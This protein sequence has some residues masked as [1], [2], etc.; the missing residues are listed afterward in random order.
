MVEQ[1]NVF[2]YIGVE[3]DLL[4]QSLKKLERGDAVVFG[5]D[6]ARVVVRF[7]AFG[8]YEIVSDKKKVHEGFS[9][10]KACYRFLSSLGVD[11]G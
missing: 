1:M 5:T 3:N 8:L 4:F 10:I 9:D 7:N 6:D 11:L 2:D